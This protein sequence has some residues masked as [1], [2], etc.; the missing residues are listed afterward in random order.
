MQ[1][2]T[3]QNKQTQ[4]NNKTAHATYNDKPTH[5]KHKTKQTKLTDT[6]NIKTIENKAIATTKQTSNQEKQN[7]IQTNQTTTKTQA[8][9]KQTQTQNKANKTN[10]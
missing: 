3:T 4:S 10:E 9:T 6:G 5:S 7:N 8:I 2:K 1:T